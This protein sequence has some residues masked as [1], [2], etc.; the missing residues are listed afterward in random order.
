M[1]TLPFSKRF[2][3]HLKTILIHKKWVLFYCIKAGI[4]FQGIVHDLSKFHPVEFFEG[5][6]YY[7]GDVSPIVTAK[8]DKGY[9]SAWFHH[10]GRNK[11]HYEFWMDKFDDGG[12]NI[13]MPEKYAIE[14]ICDYLAAGRAYSGSSFTYQKEREWWQAR[15][16]KPLAMH[17]ALQA[18]T[19]ACIDYMT[20]SEKFPPKD[21][22][23]LYYTES[24]RVYKER[25]PKDTV[26]IPLHRKGD[27][28]N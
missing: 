7:T 20:A 12:V 2:F 5:V 3:G 10:K 25:Y 15:K 22:I 6:K 9:S 21:L 24:I 4:P 23:H 13:M 8:K 27:N 18:F 11:H 26:S 16:K 28:G 14:Q 1:T 17:P 19:T